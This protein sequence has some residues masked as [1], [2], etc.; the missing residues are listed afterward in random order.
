[1]FNINQSWR[2]TIGKIVKQ[3]YL[4][5]G[6]IVKQIYLKNTQLGTN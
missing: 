6:K 4:I 2:W 5:I 1:M 3:I